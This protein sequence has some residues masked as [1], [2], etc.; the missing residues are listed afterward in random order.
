SVSDTISS[1]AIAGQAVSVVPPPRPR[2]PMLGR[3]RELA[4]AETLL[5]RADVG[6][7]TLTGAGGSGKTR[8]ALAVAARQQGHFADG[9]AWVPLALVAAADQ[10]LPAVARAVGVREIPNE[11]LHATLVRV[12]SERAL[13]LVLDNF[14]HVLAAAPLISELLLSCTGL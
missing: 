3:E 8:L 5:R 7:V 11:Q 9:V 10:V 13:L 6:L 1:A 2:A 14:E 4:L 12:L